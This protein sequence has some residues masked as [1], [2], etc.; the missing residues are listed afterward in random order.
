MRQCLFC[1]ADADS[2]EDAW[3]RWIT[4]QFKGTGPSEVRAERGGTKLKSWSVLQPELTIRCVCQA[5]NIG[6]MSQ[7]EGDVKPFLQPLLTG[8]SCA[9]DAIGQTVIALWAVKTAMVLEALDPIEKRTYVQQQRERLRLRETIPWRTSIWLAASADPAWFM[10]TKNRHMGAAEGAA[11]V[12]ITMAFA[13]VA[14]QVLT[15][16]VPETVGP[17][18]HVT[19]DVRR[20]PLDQLTV[21]VWPPRATVNWPPPMGL[22]G[23]MGLD[24]FAERFSAVDHNS[25]EVETLAV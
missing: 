18:T 12:S 13:H 7:L 5:C 3:P 23:E 8:E 10:S 9:V 20:G 21:Q 22:N 11:G 25:G 19:T 17:I 1:P 2:L 6:W 16:R 24:A 4:D 15:I 14:L